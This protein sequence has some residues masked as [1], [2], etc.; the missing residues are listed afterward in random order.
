MLTCFRHLTNLYVVT[1][2][3]VWLPADANVTVLCF[4]PDGTVCSE[5]GSVCYRA[6]ERRAPRF[7]GR[8]DSV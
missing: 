3:F 4:E 1:S 7:P 2:L 6:I 5:D 8:E